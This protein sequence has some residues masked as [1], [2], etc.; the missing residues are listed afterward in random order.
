[1]P[2]NQQDKTGEGRTFRKDRPRARC[3]LVY[4]DREV[5]TERTEDGG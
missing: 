2:Y 1:L 5:W 4:R 3:L